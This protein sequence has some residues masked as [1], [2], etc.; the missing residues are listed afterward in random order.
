VN[1]FVSPASSRSSRPERTAAFL[2]CIVFLFAEIFPAE[3]P[4]G[5]I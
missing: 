5:T 1:G 2:Q 3:Q 4:E